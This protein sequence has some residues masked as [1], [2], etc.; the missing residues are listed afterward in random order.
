[1]AVGRGYITNRVG[2]RTV[3]NSLGANLLYILFYEGYIILWFDFDLCGLR[4][5][6][7]VPFW[8][9]HLSTLWSFSYIL[10]HSRPVIL[11]RRAIIM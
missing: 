9:L 5:Q 2:D 3:E 7:D 11:A 8:R 6:R 10:D 4:H 1:M